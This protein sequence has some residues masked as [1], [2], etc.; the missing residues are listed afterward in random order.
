MTSFSAELLLY[1]LLLSLFFGLENTSE[2]VCLP[3][4]VSSR[5][6]CVILHGVHWCITLSW[7]VTHTVRPPMSVMPAPFFF[8]NRFFYCPTVLSPFLFLLTP[9]SPIFSF[10]DVSLLSHFL[11][12]VFFFNFPRTTAASKY[13]PRNKRIFNNELCVSVTWGNTHDA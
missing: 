9:F 13:T 8:S 10:L 6:W 2:W 3:S 11:C 4:F 5:H 7:P 12:V 1:T